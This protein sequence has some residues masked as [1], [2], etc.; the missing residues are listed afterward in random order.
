MTSSQCPCSLWR[1]ID[2]SHGSLMTSDPIIS[3]CIKVCA[4]DGGSGWCLGCG[5]TLGEIA[6]WA[7]MAPDERLVIMK[8]LPRRMDKL[9]AAG[10]LG[11]GG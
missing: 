9:K 10:K 3:P 5:R 2:D 6:R 4:V 11:E 1:T 7:S 8:D